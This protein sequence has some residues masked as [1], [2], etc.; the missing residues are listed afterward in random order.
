MTTAA[1]PAPAPAAA[2]PPKAAKAAK[3][4][5]AA[6]AHPAFKVMIADAIKELKER[7][8]S[9]LAA[10]KKSVGAKYGSKL[11]A[12]WEKKVLTHMLG[13]LQRNGSCVE[14]AS[15]DSHTSCCSSVSRLYAFPQ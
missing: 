1:A 14:P 11:A 13:L 2:K 4:P 12:G 10:V 7:N 15:W 8:G 6:P 9:S 5:K 3:A